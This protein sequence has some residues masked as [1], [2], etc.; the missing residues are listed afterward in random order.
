LNKE[1]AQEYLDSA[2]LVD[3][4]KQHAQFSTGDAPIYVYQEAK[5][6]QK[7]TEEA[8]N[9]DDETE[10]A[11][12]ESESPW[13]RVNDK[14]PVWMRSVRCLCTKILADKSVRMQRS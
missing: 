4:V 6:P 11:S 12:R 2:K 1:N 8:E 7:V 3:L 10:A 5:Q 9:A 14:A 13:L